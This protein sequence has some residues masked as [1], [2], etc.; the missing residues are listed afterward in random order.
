MGIGTGN[1]PCKLI[2]RAK[3]A[4]DCGVLQYSC[5]VTTGSIAKA[6][7]SNHSVVLQY[8]DNTACMRGISTCNTRQ[9]DRTGVPNREDYVAANQCLTGLI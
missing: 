8:Y 7:C 2:S 9:M 5:L 1:G 4:V 6:Y 3:L